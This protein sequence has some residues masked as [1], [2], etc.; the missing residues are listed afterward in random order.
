MVVLLLSKLIIFH[1][2]F[3]F[4]E[5]DVFPFRADVQVAILATYGTIATGG[6]LALKRRKLDFVLDGCAMTVCI[7]PDFR[8]FLRGCHNKLCV[9]LFKADLAQMV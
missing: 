4:D 5:D 7:I 9:F 2:V 8:W 6:L 3:T 1:Q